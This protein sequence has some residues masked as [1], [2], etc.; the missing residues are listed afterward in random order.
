M[1]YDPDMTTKED[2][3]MTLD[4]LITLNLCETFLKTLA[5]VSENSFQG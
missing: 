4:G 3:D 2:M 1:E 5:V